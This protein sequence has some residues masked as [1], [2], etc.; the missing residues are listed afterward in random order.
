MSFAPMGACN[1][2]VAVVRE[3][4]NIPVLEAITVIL[5]FVSRHRVLAGV[6]F[7]VIVFVT[8]VDFSICRLR[9][10]QATCCLRRHLKKRSVDLRPCLTKLGFVR[11]RT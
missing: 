6:G 7:T 2:A 5:T 1:G 10:P 4:E 8:G 9:S 11:S 3:M